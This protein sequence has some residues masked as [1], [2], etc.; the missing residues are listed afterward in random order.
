MLQ[1]PLLHQSLPPPSH[2]A[3]SL[4]PYI[5]SSG[6]STAEVRRGMESGIMR[7]RP[8]VPCL[9][10]AAG[11]STCLC[12]FCLPLT[13]TAADKQ[14]T[15]SPTQ[16]RQQTSLESLLT[17]GRDTRSITA[18]PTAPR[19]GWQPW[20][21]QAPAAESQRPQSTSTKIELADRLQKHPLTITGSSHCS[22]ALRL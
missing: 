13:A 12:P 1:L 4:Y 8:P 7:L 9:T 2:S 14:S 6:P 19:R 3:F 15:R 11:L 22:S 5:A 10:T 16:E 20:L 18:S 21:Q 17:V